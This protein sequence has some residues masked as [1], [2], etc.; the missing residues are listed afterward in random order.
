MCTGKSL[1]TN[2]LL[3]IRIVRFDFKVTFFW[4][5]FI[6]KCKFRRF[7]FENDFSQPLFTR[8]IRYQY[9]I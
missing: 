1:M 6:L 9:A 5:T 3:H 2:T 4:R 8:L 7:Y